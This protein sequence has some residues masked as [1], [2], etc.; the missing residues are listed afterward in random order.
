M[1][2]CYVTDRKLL[3]ARAEEELRTRELLQY[4]ERAVTAGVDWIQIREKDLC[5]RELA[6]LTRRAVA[7]AS[8]VN[9][10]GHDVEKG[11]GLRRRIMVN[12][13]I[14]VALAA[15]A[16]GVH[17]G[18]GSVPANEAIRWLRAGN[19]PAD[20]LTGISC[21]GRNEALAAERA[22]ANYIFFGPIY[23]TPSK[24]AFGAPQGAAKLAEICK[25]VKIPV[26]AIG[27]I[28][29]E[30]AAE[31]LRAGAAG[32]AAIRLFQQDIEGSALA[33]MISRLRASAP[34]TSS[35]D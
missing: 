32:I 3:F 20:F 11:S 22:G 4:I 24:K 5:A 15:E 30:N 8:K 25:A 2:F 28:T 17:L 34:A 9:A 18:S 16:H 31:C 29:E 33:G 26:L 10:H 19:A 6:E 27:G 1:L 21:H 12:D 14:D 13:R 7:V 35:T 23:E